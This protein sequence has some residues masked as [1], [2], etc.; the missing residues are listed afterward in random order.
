RVEV[1]LGEATV[2]D[3]DRLGAK[4]VDPRID[5]DAILVIRGGETA[6]DQGD[7][8]HVLDAMVAIRGV[9]ERTLL[10]DDAD[11]RFVGA[12]GDPAY[13]IEPVS[14]LGMKSH[15]TFDCGLG[16]E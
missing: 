3:A 14:D 10:V 15:R 4:R 5:S 16:V 2:L 9:G 1:I 8:D 12:D 13:R 7:R 11:R 6:E